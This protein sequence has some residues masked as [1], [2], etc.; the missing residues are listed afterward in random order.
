MARAKTRVIKEWERSC[1]TEVEKQVKKEIADQ[2]VR[3]DLVDG[4]Y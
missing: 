4:G 3:T 2:K 1:P